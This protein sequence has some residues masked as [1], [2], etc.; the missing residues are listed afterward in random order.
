MKRI[1]LALSA[2]LLVSIGINAETRV[3]LGKAGTLASL[4][5]Q[6]QQDTNTSLVIEGPINSADIRLLRRM[7]GYREHES[8]SRILLGNK[9]SE[10]R[11]TI[12]SNPHCNPCAQMHKR[13][14]TLIF[15]LLPYKQIYQLKRIKKMTVRSFTALSN[16]QIRCL[17]GGEKPKERKPFY[18]TCEVGSSVY[19]YG[20]DSCS[21]EV[22]D[23]YCPTRDFAY[24]VGLAK[25]EPQV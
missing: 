8:D 20:V 14:D 11:I 4:L 18:L 16:E 7:A 3:T 9:N 25:D 2:L 10:T 6:V 12:L 13:V 17:A 15:T 1:L 21:R 19:Y 5:S 24:C 22:V 23:T